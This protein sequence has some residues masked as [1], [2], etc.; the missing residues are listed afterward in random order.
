M[1][2]FLKYLT[3]ALLLSLTFC[4]I[5]FG[6]EEGEAIYL[7]PGEQKIIPITKLA[8]I[9]VGNGKIIEV[10]FPK[11]KNFILLVAKSIGVSS[12]I[13]WV[14]DKKTDLYTVRVIEPSLKNMFSEIE[15][16]LGGIEGI[17]VNLLG[18]KII[19]EGSLYKAQDK[20]K[21]ENLA[22]G[23]DMILDMTKI[24]KEM[25][26]FT[27][28]LIKKDLAEKGFPGIE[29]Q[30]SGEK[31][32]LRGE[33]RSKEESEAVLDI[34]RSIFPEISHSLKISL[35][36]EKM[37]L[38]D[39]KMAEIKKT[40]SKSLGIKWQDSV[41][42]STNFSKS[43]GSGAVGTFSLGDGFNTTLNVM[44]AKGLV[45]I[46]ANP[47]LVLKN[48]KKGSFQA[49]GEI[50]IRLVGERTT[51]VIFKNYGVILQITPKIDR[52]DNV[53]MEINVEISDINVSAS[54]DGIPGIS[55]N[56]IETEINI[57]AGETIIL[58]GLIENRASKNVDKIP[59]LGQIPIL[60][61]LFKSRSF[62]NNES[63]FAVL[64]TPVI[65]NPS[66]KENIDSI[67]NTENSLRDA[68]TKLKPKVSD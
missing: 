62:N 65:I 63:S 1:K 35:E 13:L 31:I 59:L 34:A 11:N 14:E 8:R 42:F 52:E 37:V 29:V 20:R 6:V 44:E 9:A 60:G 68:E 2:L 16:S 46:L 27:A 50:P 17:S 61:E 7:A 48:G 28:S 21:V 64:L 67:Q 18:Q 4:R 66:T 5:S 10:K 30:P 3:V 54:V 53:S 23:N 22:K 45:K 41:Q 39:L 24:N 38:V 36:L 57:R 58:A 15:R 43:T 49:G 51:N 55:K 25:L 26:P 56:S 12:L 33:V 32:F 19:I 40:A 47:K